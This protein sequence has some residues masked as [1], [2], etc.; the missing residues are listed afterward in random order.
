[1]QTESTFT[2]KSGM[3]ANTPAVRRIYRNGTEM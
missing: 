1:M 3:E 2:R